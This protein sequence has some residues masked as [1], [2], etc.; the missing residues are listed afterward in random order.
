MLAFVAAGFSF[1]LGVKDSCERLLLDKLG[2][3]DLDAGMI[4][5]LKLGG[6]GERALIIRIP[7]RS[8]PHVIRSGLMMSCVFA[9]LQNTPGSILFCSS[10][11]ERERTPGQYRK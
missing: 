6:G 5:G 7:G 11:D 4:E 1:T 10:V 2:A 9:G 8:S 3:S